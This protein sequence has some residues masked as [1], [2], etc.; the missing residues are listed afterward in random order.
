VGFVSPAIIAFKM[1]RPLVEIT[2]HIQ[3]ISENARERQHKLTSVISDIM[4]NLMIWSYRA[5]KLIA[6]ASQY[7]SHER[8]DLTAEGGAPFIVEGLILLKCSVRGN[9]FS[10][11]LLRLDDL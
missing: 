6:Q 5:R 1:R 11:G 3:R 8:G 9:P 4:G 2:Q 10:K 7:G